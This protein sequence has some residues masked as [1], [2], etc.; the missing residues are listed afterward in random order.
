MY[1]INNI[2]DKVYLINLEKDTNKY[3]IMKSK[4]DKLNIKFELFKAIDGKKLTNCKLLKF[5]NKGA[6]GYKMSCMEIIKSAKCNNY[7]KILI[8]EDDLYFL[9]DFIKEFD[10]LYKDLINLDSSWKLLY[11]G[12]SNRTKKAILIFLKVTKKYN[13]LVQD[14]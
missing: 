5:G 2:F 9:K 8:L 11:F 1:T 13:I 10:N 14:S 4:L 7:S 6:V 12:A 3:Q